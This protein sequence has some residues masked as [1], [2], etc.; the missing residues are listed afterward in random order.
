[1]KGGRTPIHIMRFAPADYLNDPAVKLALAEDNVDATAFYPLFLFNAFAQ[2]GSLTSDLRVLA[3]TIGMS[4]KRVE[5]ALAFWK[6][7]GTIEDRDG[8]LY[9]KRVT[10][11]VEQELA[12]RDA[13]AERKRLAR[14]RTSGGRPADAV[15]TSGGRRPESEAPTPAPAPAPAP[16]PAPAPNA[17]AAR[18]P[19]AP[20]YPGAPPEGS[21]VVLAPPRFSDQPPRPPAYSPAERAEQSTTDEIRRLQNTLGTK[22]AALSEHPNNRGAT[23]GLALTVTQWCR[24]VTSYTRADGGSASGAADY[25]TVLRI[26]RLEKSIADAEWWLAELEKGPIPEKPDKPPAHASGGSGGREVTRGA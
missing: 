16:L 10:R 26:D 14:E 20:E 21:V 24:K 1:M 15:D 25:R 3:A 22:L 17:S 19:P 4:R 13:E 6:D 18:Q 7:T 11:E 2:G 12:F 23:S 5:R 9:Q 8:R